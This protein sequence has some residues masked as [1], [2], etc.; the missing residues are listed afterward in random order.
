MPKPLTLEQV[1]LWIDQEVDEFGLED[2]R[3]KYQIAGDSPNFHTHI[4]RLIDQHYIKRIRRATYRKVKWAQ[5]IKVFG[6]QRRPTVILKPPEDR[7]TGEP[8]DF[9]NDIVFREGDLMLIS[10]FKNRGKTNLCLNLIAENLDKHPVL[11]GNEYTVMGKDGE[12]EPSPRLLNRL[13]SMTWVD[14]VNVS[15]EER[16]ELLP[17]YQDY[18]EQVRSG[19]LNVIDWVN[20][21]GEYYM[22]SPVMEE[23]KRALGTGMAIVVLQKNPGSEHG[24]G[25]NPSKDF[26]DVELLLDPFGEDK[27]SVMLTVETVK[28]AKQAVQGRHFVYKIRHGVEIVNFREVVKCGNCFGRGWRKDRPC[29]V[30]AKLGYVDKARK[31]EYAEDEA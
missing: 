10:G 11:M 1:K 20:L 4:Q 5:P 22:I 25:G 14:W 13:D 6:R 29:D 31:I 17:V 21:A 15:N 8:M 7:D 2:F 24:R 19:R 16:F 3:K 30:C 18:A 23:I 9:L 26:A 28:E 27:D 12:F